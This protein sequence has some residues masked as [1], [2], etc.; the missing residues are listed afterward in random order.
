VK[1][2]IKTTLSIVIFVEMLAIGYLT[3]P[4]SKPLL[5]SLLQILHLITFLAFAA[6][7]ALTI[8]K[9]YPPEYALPTLILMVGFIGAYVIGEHPSNPTTDIL[10]ILKTCLTFVIIDAGMALTLHSHDAKNKRLRIIGAVFM[11]APIILLP[12]IFNN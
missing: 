8:R 12:I 10:T 3:I 5:Y 2:N 6:Y 4:E 7:G 11:I 1:I 9:K